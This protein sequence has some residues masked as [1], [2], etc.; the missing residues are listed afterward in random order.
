MIA[1]KEWIDPI[2]TQHASEVGGDD[3]LCKATVIKSI[4]SDHEQRLVSGIVSTTS[5]DLD[6]EIVVPSGMDLSYFPGCV[7]AVYLNHDYSSLPVATCRKLTPQ[8]D[9]L[10]CQTYI[11]RGPMGDDLLLAIE[12][13]AV[14]G[15]SVGF[16]PIDFGPPTMDERKAY[17]ECDT[18]VRSSKLLEYSIVSMP[19]NP[20]AL[21]EMVSKGKIRRESAVRFG[22]DDSPVR[23]FHA[24]TERTRRVYDCGDDV[25]LA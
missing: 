7:K 3:V 8:G 24:V 18:V 4:K 13:G 22:L 19:A 14:N 21:I 15:F 12:D 6:N 16:K 11:R 1:F 9:A 5:V 2:A 23:K 17:G 25:L 20:D 10:F